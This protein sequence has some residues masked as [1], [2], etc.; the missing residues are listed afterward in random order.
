M[1]PL[2]AAVSLARAHGLAVDEPVV[3]RDLSNLL[4]HLRPAPVVARV[5]TTTA[6]ARAGGLDWLERE[7]ELARFLVTRGAP[8]VA[9]AAELPPGPHLNEG[10]AIT[11]WH[12]VDHDPDRPP[13]GA[14]VGAALRVLHEELE[15]YPAELPGLDAMLD[16]VERLIGHLEG[17]DGLLQGD[18][19]R[20]RSALE[21]SR[22]GI[23]AAG[24][25]ERA[26][27]GDAHAGN[28]LS[29]SSGPLWTDLEDT[30]RGPVEWDLACLV[31]SARVLG[32]EAKRSAEAFAAYGHDP[33]DPGLEPFVDARSLQT[34]AWTAFMAERHPHLR[35]RARLW[36]DALPS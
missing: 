1:R 7:V 9:P 18:L 33:A 5:A 24:L 25:P 10:W 15:P 27:H 3:L 16:E 26:L 31:A 6:A 4:V 28:L 14:E 11:F 36:L 12:H 13:P 32:L 8:V 17:T 19:E 34:A 35:E 20:L 30:C 21:R 23:A 29:T 22:A 2:E